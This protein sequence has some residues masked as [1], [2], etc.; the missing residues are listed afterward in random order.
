MGRESHE[1]DHTSVI[2]GLLKRHELREAFEM[3]V[4]KRYPAGA[5][6]LGYCP[7]GDMALIFPREKEKT[8]RS[9]DEIARESLSCTTYRHC[10]ISL[11]TEQT[12]S[13]ASIQ[14]LVSGEWIGLCEQMISLIEILSRH[15]SHI[16]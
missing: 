14:I 11:S 3:L 4:D 8:H 13:P 15:M 16:R 7:Y 12:L 10:S 6:G 2:E 9:H 1:W 5:M